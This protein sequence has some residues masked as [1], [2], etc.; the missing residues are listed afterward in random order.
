MMMGVKRRHLGVE[1]GSF[2]VGVDFKWL[3]VS[4]GGGLFIVGMN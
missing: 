3:V 2:L 4:P 1:V